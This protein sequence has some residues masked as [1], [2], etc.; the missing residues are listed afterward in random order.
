MKKLPSVCISCGRMRFIGKLNRE[1]PCK[2]CQR[3]KRQFE[4]ER[5][6]RERTGL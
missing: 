6:E 3:E 5:M 2:R 1:K 4:I